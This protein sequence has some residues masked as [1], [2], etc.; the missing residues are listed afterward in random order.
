VLICRLRRTFVGRLEG[1]FGEVNCGTYVWPFASC[2]NE[3]SPTLVSEAVGSEGIFWKLVG[4]I[5]GV[6]ECTLDIWD[7]KL[8]VDR[9]G[10]PKPVP[11]DVKVLGAVGQSVVGSQCNAALI[12][13]KT[14]TS[15]VAWISCGRP[16]LSATPTSIRLRGCKVRS[17]C[18]RAENS[19]SRVDNEISVWS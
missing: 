1:Q 5:V 7:L 12:F 13:S 16:I 9:R 15:I 8:L 11:L 2:P 17:A 19:A 6:L 3:G 18:D 14:S 10:M 4:K